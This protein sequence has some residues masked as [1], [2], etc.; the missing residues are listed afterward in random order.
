V[1]ADGTLWSWGQNG[2]VALG[3][4]EH[5][6]ENPN[7]PG[8]FHGGLVVTEALVP[9]AMRSGMVMAAA[10]AL[11]SVALDA[12]GAVWTWGHAGDGKLGHACPHI[13]ALYMWYSSCVKPHPMLTG[14]QEIAAGYYH[15]LAVDEAG[16]VWTWGRNDEGQLGDGSYTDRPIPIQLQ[17]LTDVVAVAAG[18]YWNVALRAD[19]SVWEWGGTGPGSVITTPTPVPGLADIRLV[20]A[21]RAH[22]LAVDAAGRLFAWGNNAYGQLGIGSTQSVLGPTVVLTDVT[23]AAAGSDHSIAV[24]TDGTVWGWGLNYE[25][26]VGDGTTLQRL[27]PVQVQAPANT[28]RVVAGYEISFAIGDDGSL[29]GWGKNNYGQVGD[30][31]KV[32]QLAAVSVMPPKSFSDGGP[33][34]LAAEPTDVEVVH[35][36]TDAIGSVRLITDAAG[37]M[38]ARY[39]FA[40]FGEEIATAGTSWN[41]LRFA[42]K[43]RDAA[44]GNGPTWLALDYSGARH[45]QGQAARFAAADPISITDARLLNPQRLNRYVYAINNP[46]RY[47]DPNGLD[48]ITYDEYGLEI[49]RVRQSKWHNFWFGH[50]FHIMTMSGAFRIADPLRPLSGGDTYTA[51]GSEETAKL[52]T[53]FLD[54]YS[55]S[56]PGQSLSYGAIIQRATNEWNW[57]LRLNA[58]YGANALFMLEGL[59]QRSDY[60]GNYAFGYLMN[61]WNPLG[62]NTALAKWGGAAFNFYD[63]SRAGASPF[64]G[65]LTTGF[66]DPRDFVAIDA[67]AAR[68]RRSR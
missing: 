63:S 26:Q 8:Q 22:F 50:T 17:G 52:M 16:G 30:G 20:R 58:H 19:G 5:K 47:V 11:H 24:K 14:M 40:P 2:N 28:V 65:P 67:G 45:Y 38:K 35:Y 9:R 57:K 44:T 56:A 59:G 66:D 13:A 34:P 42:G 1:R 15:T 46:L 60:L 7:A 21:G 49:D 18:Q 3:Y 37:A 61:A 25:G 29:T 36:H 55:P 12:N 27:S 43:E 53:D 62:P 51:V 41:T 33:P 68:Y 23:D 64:R 32:N 4:G 39:D 54:A 10:G 6:I 48:V 31:T